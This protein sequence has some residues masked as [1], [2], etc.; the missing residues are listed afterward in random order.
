MHKSIL[1]STALLLASQAVQSQTIIVNYTGAVTSIGSYLQGDG[2]TVGSTLNASFSYDT[3]TSGS[4]TSFSLSFD[5]GFTSASSN[6]SLYVQNDTQNGSATLHA[7]GLIIGSGATSS[8]SLNGYSNPYMQ[9][10]LLK[11]NVAGQLWSSTLPPTLT[12]WSNVTLAD[13][14]KPDWHWMDFGL[15]TSNFWDD[16]IR[17]DVTSFDVSVSEVPVPAAIIMFTPALLGFLGLRRKP[18]KTTL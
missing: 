3:A 4:A 18:K 6:P 1:F 11:D 14:N 15:I 13:I 8:S 17:W 10:G 9:F 7:D 2:V 16:Q 12:D 5:N